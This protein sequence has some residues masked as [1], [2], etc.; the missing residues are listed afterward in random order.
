M[1]KVQKPTGEESVDQAAAEP[2]GGGPRG[3]GRG[4]GGRGRGF[5][6]RRSRS[7]GLTGGSKAE[8]ATSIE[9]TGA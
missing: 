2:G 9:D 7:P 4:R 1:S 5:P 8:E 3:G 6:S